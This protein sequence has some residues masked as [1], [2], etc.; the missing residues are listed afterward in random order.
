MGRYVLKRILLMIP[1]IIGV[2]FVIF[3]AMNL[4]AGD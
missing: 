2:S 4:A 3:V 1:V